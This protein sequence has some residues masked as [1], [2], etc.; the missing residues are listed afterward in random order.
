MFNEPD[1]P[2]TLRALEDVVGVRRLPGTIIDPLTLPR[3]I[4]NPA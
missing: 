4:D 2:A 1:A 3:G